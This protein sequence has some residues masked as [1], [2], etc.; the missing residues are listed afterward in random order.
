MKSNKK[1]AF[2]IALAYVILAT[3]YSYWAMNNL[4]SDGVLYYI[5]FPATILPSLI[6]LTEREPGAMILLCQVVT[7][8]LIWLFIWVALHL[9]RDIKK[10]PH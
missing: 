6:L 8:V 10:Q 4:V 3:I 7:L 2:Y 9:F 1:L 5:F